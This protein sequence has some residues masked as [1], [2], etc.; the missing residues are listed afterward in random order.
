MRF[1][2]E[3][4]QHDRE[5]E[6]HPEIL[7]RSIVTWSLIRL[8]TT[9]LPWLN[10]FVGYTYSGRTEGTHSR[11]NEG[12]GGLPKERSVQTRQ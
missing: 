5:L 8:R 10:G 11:L 12:R 9:I 1:L 6:A 4:E 2:G 3:F 7:G